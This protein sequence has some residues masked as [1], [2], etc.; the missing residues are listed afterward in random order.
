MSSMLVNYHSLDCSSQLKECHS[1][2]QILNTVY[3]AKFTCHIT[4]MNGNLAMATRS[5][6]ISDQELLS[7][8]ATLFEK[9]L[10]HPPMSSQ[11]VQKVKELQEYVTKFIERDKI[12]QQSVEA[13]CLTHWLFHKLHATALE[14]G[15]SQEDKKP[16]FDIE[17]LLLRPVLSVDENRQLL[18]I[19]F[20]C[21]GIYDSL[22]LLRDVIQLRQQCTRKFD[23]L[24]QKKICTVPLDDPFD[25]AINFE[26]ISDLREIPPLYL[27]LQMQG[28][29]FPKEEKKQSWYPLFKKLVTSKVPEE[30]KSHCY[31]ILDALSTYHE[32]CAL[33][34][35][36]VK[37]LFFTYR[38]EMEQALDAD[39]MKRLFSVVYTRDR[40]STVRTTYMSYLFKKT[41][42]CSR[43]K[44]H[45]LS[46]ELDKQQQFANALQRTIEDYLVVVQGGDLYCRIFQKATDANGFA[47]N[48][49]ISPEQFAQKMKVLQDP[50]PSNPSFTQALLHE[51]E[52]DLRRL[53]KAMQELCLS[54]GAPV[55]QPPKK[56]KKKK[57]DPVV[58]V[59]SSPVTNTYVYHPRVMRWW[60]QNP[61]VDPFVQDPI[62]QHCLPET[63]KRI[64]S[65]HAF[66][67][68]VDR[69]AMRQKKTNGQIVVV[70]EL[71]G[72]GAVK[73]GVFGYAFDEKGVCYHRHFTEKCLT[74]VCLA[75]F[76]K[77]SYQ[78]DF[79]PLLQDE[80]KPASLAEIV[81]DDG[82][83]VESETDEIVVI[84]NPSDNTLIRL[85]HF[86]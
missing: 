19:L 45:Y 56:I 10:L 13:E 20:L 44:L 77:G 54:T 72:H 48:R 84:K 14:R 28:L 68:A 82:S 12:L 42:Q 33:F 66:A 41:K 40:I 2:F 8:V 78:L 65:E 70:G 51:E 71:V 73:R 85:C 32:Y 23:E 59:P 27:V 43:Y 58:S 3:R 37:P 81:S 52:E 11:D 4:C 6:H 7:L 62:Y 9:V 57:V 74:E 36:T 63:Q 60:S 24:F 26:H 61:E 80:K 49:F 1:A 53:Q 75:L 38:K 64:R 47:K 35:K 50:V 55:S 29:G 30:I 16:S 67:L 31:Q 34:Q 22:L 86:L 39:C 79:P 83:V 69:Y 15:V 21:S 46:I 25:L 17:R 76:Q 5:S 18:R